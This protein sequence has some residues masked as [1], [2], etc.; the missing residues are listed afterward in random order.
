MKFKKFFDFGAIFEW[1][2]RNKTQTPS[3]LD[4]LPGT[5]PSEGRSGGPQKGSCLGRRRLQGPG[6]GWELGSA[7][8]NSRSPRLL[9]TE[10]SRRTVCGPSVRR[11]PSGSQKRQDPDNLAK[12]GFPQRPSPLRA[13]IPRPGS[14]G[15]G[16]RPLRLPQVP[17]GPQSPGLAGEQVPTPAHGSGE[18]S[19]G[20]PPASHQL[21]FS[22][23][24]C[25]IPVP[26]EP[27]GD[28]VAP[29]PPGGPGPRHPAPSSGRL[30]DP[31]VQ[32]PFAQA[33]PARG[34]EIEGVQ[35]AL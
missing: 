26:L 31:E 1:I 18:A 6:T 3:G 10:G 27:E 25:S 19:R 15:V 7:A 28:P 5:D 14:P 9:C 34:I 8:R 33:A 13:A 12:P 20:C 32:R 35:T 29:S 16:S 11:G 21:P 2:E 4:G 23:S 17:S 30:Q 24:P 22:L